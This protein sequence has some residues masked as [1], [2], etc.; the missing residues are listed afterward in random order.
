MTTLQEAPARTGQRAFHHKRPGIATRLRQ[1]WMLYLI[2]LP[3]LVHL[4]LFKLGPLGGMVIAFQDFSPFRGVFGSDWVGFE[5]FAKF[6]DDPYIPRLVVNTLLLALLTLL[7]TFPVPVIFAL[8]LNEVRNTYLRRTVQT[9]SFLPYFVSSAVIVSILYTFLSPQ[10]GLVNELLAGFGIK[11][12]FFMAESGWFRPLYVL[13]SVWQTFGYATVIYIAAMTAIDPSLYEA[14]RID[15][16]GRWRMMWSVTLPSI[17]RMMIV[18]FILN[19]G[20]ILSVDIDKVLLMYSPSVYETA[21]VIQTYVYRQAFAPG[22]FPDY[23]YG[24]AVGIVQA[25][26]ALVLIVGANRVAKRF[27]DSRVF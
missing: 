19:I 8:L 5:Q 10:G 17:S 7:F 4:V 23:S 3:G 14:A 2:L 15:G 20:Q 13:M 25:V 16:A 18:M 6:L 1:N 21:D 12:I 26:V 22:G 11:P 9:F 27:S 24:A